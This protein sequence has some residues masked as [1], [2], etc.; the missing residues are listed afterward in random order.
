MLIAV[1]FCEC[2][3]FSDSFC[4]WTAALP[5][6]VDKVTSALLIM[7][8]DERRDFSWDNAKK[9]MAKVDGGYMFVSSLFSAL[10]AFGVDPVKAMGYAAIGCLP[11]F[12]SFIGLVADDAQVFGLN[13]EQWTVVLVLFIGASA[14]GMLT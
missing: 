11:L 3:I 5:A 7:I 4:L 2:L 6:G 9:M 8:K 13:P 10:L 14:F 1:L 12:V